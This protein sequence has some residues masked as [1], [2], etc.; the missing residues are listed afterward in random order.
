MP[1]L[2]SLRPSPPPSRP[3]ALTQASRSSS[4][5]LPIAASPSLSFPPSK[6]GGGGVLP[7]LLPTMFLCPFPTSL[8]SPPVTVSAAVAPASASQLLVF[9][10]TSFDSFHLLRG[11]VSHQSLIHVGSYLSPTEHVIPLISHAILL[12]PSRFHIAFS[13]HDTHCTL[14]PISHVVRLCP[15]A[16]TSQSHSRSIIH[17]I[18]YVTRLCP[19]RFLIALSYHNT[20]YCHISFPY[21]PTL[22]FSIPLSLPCHFRSIIH[23]YSPVSVIFDFLH[24]LTS[25]HPSLSHLLSHT[26][27]LC[28]SR[29][30][31]PH[32]S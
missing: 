23:Q 27:Q 9:L 8:G 18:S 4:T 21:R 3:G 24:I 10:L 19:S 12:Y 11:S 20:H 25:Q 29:I 22:S 13:C 17:I 6:V 26:P 5:L 31:S 32:M 28:L 15:G 14:L 16:S 1:P 30:P 7:P 2:F